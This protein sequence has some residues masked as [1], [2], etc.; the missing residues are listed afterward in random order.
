LA[1]VAA[2]A[3]VG[4]LTIAT[5]GLLLAARTANAQVVSGLSNVASYPM[6]LCSGVFFS[7]DRFPAAL[8]PLVRALPLTLLLDALRAVMLEGAPL[9]AVAPKV[10]GLAA[11]GFASFA[12]ALKLFKWR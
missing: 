5:L 8:R 7:A 2:I 12:L 9:A 11:W 4:A 3:A 6:S 1:A 10:A